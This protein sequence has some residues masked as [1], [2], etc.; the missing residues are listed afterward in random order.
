[1]SEIACLFGIETY[2]LRGPGGCASGWT[3]LHTVTLV[4]VLACVGWIVGKIRGD[5]QEE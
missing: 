4:G 2:A 5:S 1:M 3:F